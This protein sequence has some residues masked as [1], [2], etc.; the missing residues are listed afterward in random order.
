MAWADIRPT[1]RVTAPLT[2]ATLPEARRSMCAPYDGQIKA[3]LVHAGEPIH[4][5][6]TLFVMDTDEVSKQY[7]KAYSEAIAHARRRDAYAA[8]P[9]KIAERNVE[10]AQYDASRVEA[11]LYKA[12]VEQGTVV[13]PMDGQVLSAKGE[14][15]DKVNVEVKQGEELMLFGD[16][17]QLWAEMQ[18]DDRDIQDVSTD[19]RGQLATT[20][21]PTAKVPFTVSTVVPLGAPRE[22]ANVFTVYGKVDPKLVPPGW[23]PGMT[24][25]ARIDVGRRTWAWIWTHRLVDFVRLKLWM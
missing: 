11:D 13:A 17:G 4:K 9:T 20:S 24:G 23:R 21:E 7:Y 19:E 10:Q 6:Q 15:S 25:E 22:G 8:D 1:Y 14:L 3:V 12:R 2:F 5:G 18:V 16:P